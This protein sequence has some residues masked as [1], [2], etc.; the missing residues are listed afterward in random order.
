MQ[1]M[2][3]VRVET[4][5]DFL[6]SIHECRFDAKAVEY[7][8]ELNSDISATRN[9]N[10]FRQLSEMKRFVGADAIFMSVHGFGHA[11]MTAGRNQYLVCSNATT[12]CLQLDSM[13][14]DQFGAAGKNFDIGI[15]EALG[16][17]PFKPGNFFVL[18]IDQLFPVKRRCADIPTI[19][20]C[21]LE[22]LRKLRSI[23]EEFL[24][25]AATNNAGSAHAIF[26][27]KTDLFAHGPSET[28]CPNTART[29]ADNK[30]IIVE[31]GHGILQ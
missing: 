3:Q 7:V 16:V 18:G 9:G 29:T 8:R 4:G 31:A 10:R 14:I 6:A 20:G 2:A 28:R 23:D 27:C 17:E 5:E 11:R 15:L 13:F 19:A 12:V 22:M 21:I 24:R 26:F 1:K 30:K 25:Y